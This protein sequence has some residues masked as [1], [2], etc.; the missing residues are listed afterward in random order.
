[1]KIGDLIYRKDIGVTY[2]ITGE[3]ESWNAWEV[4]RIT[5]RRPG[6]MKAGLVFKDDNR[7]TVINESDGIIGHGPKA[8]NQLTS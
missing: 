8:T 2:R 3:S 1:M 5:D 4:E 7:W 6:T